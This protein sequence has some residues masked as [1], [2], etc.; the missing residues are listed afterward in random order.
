MACLANGFE[1]VR[2]DVLIGDLPEN[3]QLSRTAL[4]HGRG[5]DHRRNDG[6]QGRETPGA[7]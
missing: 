4:S 5:N 7:R 3:Q 1:R 6:Q 2:A